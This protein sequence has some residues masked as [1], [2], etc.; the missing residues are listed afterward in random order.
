VPDLDAF[1]A[2]GG[3]MAALIRGHDWAATPLG[4]IREWPQSLRSAL[5]ICL[6]SPVAMAIFWGP[7]HLFLYNDHWR[8]QLAD[9]HPSALGR[10]AAEVMA[11]IWPRLAQDFSGAFQGGEAVSVVDAHLVRHLGGSTFDSYWNYSLLPIAGEDGAIGGLFGQS[12]ETTAQVM[13]GRQEA[14]LLRLAD[15][16]RLIG[17]PAELL[18]TAVDLVA[19]SLDAGRIGWAE[20]DEGSGTVSILACRVAGTMRDTCGAYPIPDFG[21]TT[22]KDLSAGR[23]IRIDDAAT[24]PRLR[25]GSVQRLYQASQVASALIVPIVGGERYRA[26]LFAHHDTPRAWTRYE[27]ALLGAATDQIW[28][29]VSRAR[30]EAGLRESEGRYRRIFEQAYDLIVTAGLDQ[31][32]TDVNPA[33]A[34]AMELPREE[35]VGRSIR[36]FVSEEGFEQ[37]T[38]MLSAKLEKG[39]TT[40]HDLTVIARCG[41]AMQWEVNSTLT[42]DSGGRPL[43]LHAIARD[44]TERRRTEARLRLLVNELN[45]RVK[46]TLALVQGLAL[47]SFKD[48]RDPVEARSAFQERLSALASAHDLLTRE[49]WEGATLAQLVEEAVG[50]HNSPEPRIAA[51]GPHVTLGPKAA[52]SLVIALHELAT[53]AAKYG[54]LS[55]PGGKVSLVW[56]VAEGRLR[57]EWREGGGP[58]VLPPDQRGFGSRMIERALAA[59]LGGGVKIDFAPEGV[60]CRIE[61]SLA[62][63][64]P[65]LQR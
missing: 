6:R 37:T 9:R 17:D 59:D 45:H 5:S 31:V 41:R 26:M 58:A 36:E 61:A 35:I 46:N 29:E 57:L 15:R 48:G 50:H 4:P 28:R 33:A 47:Q 27:E 25:E 19:E 10:P 7:S 23:T 3:E 20:A 53:N 32:I 44:V 40:R 65:S 51:G 54:A 55:V 49:S 56:E 22:N 24:D 60:V 21:G 18:R 1:L 64:A 43:G 11:D 12:R 13:R 39:G 16:L 14:L 52:V 8:A 38:K 63:A 34:A 2:G 30:A 62:E 42:V